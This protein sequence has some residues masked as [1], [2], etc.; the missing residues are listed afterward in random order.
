MFTRSLNNEHDYLGLNETLNCFDSEPNRTKP[1][2][3]KHVKR[4][5]TSTIPYFNNLPQNQ[6]RPSLPE[7]VR[8][9]LL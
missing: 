4:C 5:P 6:V 8:P 1:N 2:Q 3:T 7:F 9:C